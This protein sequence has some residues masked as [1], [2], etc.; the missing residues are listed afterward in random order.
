MGSLPLG[1]PPTDI[2][3][4]LQPAGLDDDLTGSC[5]GHGGDGGPDV[6]PRGADFL[7]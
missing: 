1:T 7:E 6:L 4:D 2:R 3:V 5:R